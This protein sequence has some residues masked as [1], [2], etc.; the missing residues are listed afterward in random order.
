VIWC[1]ATRSLFPAKAF[2]FSEAYQ[3]KSL[4]E[5]KIYRVVWENRCQFFSHEGRPIEDSAES[6]VEVA[7]LEDLQELL[8][9]TVPRTVW[10]MQRCLTPP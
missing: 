1:T 5:L 6:A 9:R 3:N 7:P 10:P 4:S 2:Q 8:S